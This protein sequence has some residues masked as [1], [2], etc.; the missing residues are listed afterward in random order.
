MDEKEAK[1]LT[2]ADVTEAGLD[3]LI[4]NVTEA[5]EKQDDKNIMTVLSEFADKL[6]ELTGENEEEPE[7]DKAE[8]ESG[9]KTPAKDPFAEKIA[10]YKK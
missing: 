4:A 9:E 3:K 2:V 5:I 10:K 7:A 6:K 8:A 1:V